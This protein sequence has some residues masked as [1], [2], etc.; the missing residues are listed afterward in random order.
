[1]IIR[2]NTYGKETDA[3]KKRQTTIKGFPLGKGVAVPPTLLAYFL[4]V[5]CI[6]AP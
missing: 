4:N 3:L 6:S 2:V 1:M 5:K